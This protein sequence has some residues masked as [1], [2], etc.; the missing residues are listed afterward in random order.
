M[1]GHLGDCGTSHSLQTGARGSTARRI[2]AVAVAAQTAACTPGAPSLE[3]FGAYFPVWLACALIGVV[4]SIGARLLM[5]PSGL[6]R[7]LPYQVL[8]CTA[9]GAT[10]GILAGLLGFGL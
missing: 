6:S 8:T 5:V 7:Q 1:R 10:A 3:F 4:T 9:I 2:A